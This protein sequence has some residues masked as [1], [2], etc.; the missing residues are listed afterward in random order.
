MP[1]QLDLADA[2]FLGYFHGKYRSLI[3]MVEAMGLTK[4]EWTK[5]KS[6]YELYLDDADIQDIEDHFNSDES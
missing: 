1:T 2:Q 4:D 3:G 6:Q 5:L